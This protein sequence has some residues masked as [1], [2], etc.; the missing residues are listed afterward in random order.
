ME[1]KFARTVLGDIPVEKLGITDCHDHFIKNGGPE[2]EEHIDFL[3]L[4]VDASIKE[5]KEFIDRGGSTIVTM[6]PPNVG[7]DVLKTLEIANAVKNLGGNVIMS[8]GFHKAKFYDKYSSWLAVV[9]TE[10]IVKMCVAEI[11]EGMDE[12]NYNGPVVKRSKAKAGIIK[13]GTGYGAIDR[14][15]L[16]ALEVAARTS[17]LTGCPILVH[18]QLGTMALEVAKHLIG[19]GANPDKIQISHLNKN[20][21]KY[22]YEKVIKE[23]GVTLCFDGPD[24]VKYYPDSLLAENIKYLVDK[25]LQKHITLS[26]DAGRILYQRNYGLTK[27]KQTFGL[28]YLFDRFLPLL[29]QVGVSKE[30]IFDILVNNP[31]RVLAFD[32]KRNFDPLKVSKEVLELKKELNLN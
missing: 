21:D 30:A 14:L 16:K 32:E 28:A 13:A 26:L 4:N 9:P 19:F 15:E 2:V 18:T 27:G 1:N 7:R 10:E 31:K 22:Y 23:T 20:P 5:F 8:T 3:M 6:D 24:R 17:I 29:K 25:G 12:Y 11:E